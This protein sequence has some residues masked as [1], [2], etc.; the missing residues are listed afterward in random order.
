MVVADTYD[1]GVAPIQC[2]GHILAE[3]CR[4]SLY[5]YTFL[6]AQICPIDRSLG[7]ENDNLSCPSGQPME[8]NTCRGFK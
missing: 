3:R 6:A 5:L 4:R 7:P 1:F 2:L 8:M